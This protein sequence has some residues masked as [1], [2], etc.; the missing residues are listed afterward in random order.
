[1]MSEKFMFFHKLLRLLSNLYGLV[2]ARRRRWYDQRPEI[3]RRL[4]Q[5]V[6]SV[7]ALTVGGSGKTP[8]AAELSKILIS[9]GE[10]PSILSRGYRRQDPVDGVVVVRDQTA[11]RSNLEQSGDEPFMLARTL[12]E[13]SVVVCE[14]RYLAGRLAETRFG[15]TVHVMDDGFQHFNLYRDVDLVV[16]GDTDIK[17]SCTL[18]TGRLRERFDTIRL[19][20]ALIIETQTAD[21]AQEFSSRFGVETSFHFTRRLL[22]PRDPV[23]NKDAIIPIGTRVLAVAGIARPESFFNALRSYGYTIVDT[24]T[25]PDH[26]TFTESDLADLNLKLHNHE[27]DY[28]V[29]TEKDFVRL[30]PHMPL[31]FQMVW[32]PLSISIEPADRFRI[33]ISDH[34]KKARG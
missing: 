27:A 14:N 23:T 20:D 18:P 34:L 6:I 13:T 30:F 24:V 2:A 1:M 32:V 16:L 10:H 31:E 22:P 25:Y 33:W 7:G 19:A 21:E 4:Q 8:I 26:H 28:V 12:Q 5:P 11:I 15:T 3:V 17:S 9:M 29:T